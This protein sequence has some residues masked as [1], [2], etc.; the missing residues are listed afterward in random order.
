[1]TRNCLEIKLKALSKRAFVVQLGQS[2]TH[3]GMNE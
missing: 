3:T 2:S 1:M